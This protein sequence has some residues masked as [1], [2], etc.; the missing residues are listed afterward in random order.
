[1][2]AKIG[3]QSSS[4]CRIGLGVFQLLTWAVDHRTLGPEERCLVGGCREPRNQLSS[5][6]YC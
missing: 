1:M 4:C 3:K 2:D 6:L 5:G